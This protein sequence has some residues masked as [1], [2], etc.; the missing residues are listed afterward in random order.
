MEV[1]ATDCGTVKS[2]HA[3]EQAASKVEGEGQGPREMPPAAADEAM[4]PPIGVGRVVEP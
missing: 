1:V 2:A 3:S 4:K